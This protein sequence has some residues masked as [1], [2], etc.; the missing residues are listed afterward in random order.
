MDPYKILERDFKFIEPNRTKE[1]YEGAR[2]ALWTYA[3]QKD[4]VYYVGCGIKTFDEVLQETYQLEKESVHA[5]LE[6]ILKI[7]PPK[8]E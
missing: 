1:Y 4:G 3:W 5:Q 8:S 6:H 2:D 7:H